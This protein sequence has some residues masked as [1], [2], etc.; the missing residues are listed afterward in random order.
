MKQNKILVTAI[1]V[2]DLI[3]AVVCMMVYF[4]ED[5]VEPEFR[6]QADESIYNYADGKEKLLDNITAVDDRDGDISD[7]IVIEKVTENRDSA[8]IIVYYA[9]SDSA[10]NVAKI[11]RVFPTEFEE[12]ESTGQEDMETYKEAPG[13][14]SLA[15]ETL[16]EAEA[17]KNGENDGEEDRNEV[18]E[19]GD[20]NRESGN[21]DGSSE[22]NRAGTD[23][24][25][26][27]ERGNHDATDNEERNLARNEQESEQAENDVRGEETQHQD[28]AG[29]REAESRQEGGSGSPILKLSK[30]EVTVDAGNSPPW[31][32]IIEVLRDDKDNYETLYYNL[33][34]SRFNRNQPG[35]Y[36]VSLY[37]EDS[38][39]NRSETVSIM[40]HVK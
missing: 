38:D 22:E 26:R 8:T 5:R 19:T 1:I 6:F 24:A 39:G 34:V 18:E 30:E 14:E 10:G 23:D 11:S 36:P 15:V 16:S 13:E 7:R 25:G 33:S 4:G 12:L 29:E 32:E 40:V 31:T 21:E 3:L 35:D 20:E 28:D 2:V 9:V 27:N 17:Q 37:T